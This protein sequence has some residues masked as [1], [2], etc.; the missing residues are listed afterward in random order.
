MAGVSKT[1]L[2][3]R[4]LLKHYL[5]TQKFAYQIRPTKKLGA[6]PYQ[7][8]QA[9]LYNLE[10]YGMEIDIFLPE[11]RVGIEVQGLQHYRPVEFF[12][13]GDNQVFYDQQW[14]DSR[15]VQLCREQGVTLYHLDIFDLTQARFEPFIKQLMKDHGLLEQYRRTT[16]PRVLFVE[17][18]KLSRAKFK[19]S[20]KKEETATPAPSDQM[21]F[22]QKFWRLLW[23]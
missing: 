1:E 7:L 17:A 9:Y 23:S 21:S 6:R 5:P 14:R 11:W 18:E 13:R 19:P 4:G 16:S 2:T 10:L 22:M 8:L 15:K 12:T 3:A 20:S